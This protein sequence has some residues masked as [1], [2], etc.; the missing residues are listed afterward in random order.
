MT[1]LGERLAR[2]REFSGLSASELGLMAG[3]SHAIVGL[4]ERDDRPNPGA[5]TV[6]KLARVLGTTVE[7]LL[8]GVGGEPTKEKVLEAV[9]AA[10]ARLAESEL[11]LDSERPARSGTGG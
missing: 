10:R 1:G 6:L 9:E 4:L 5:L 7:Y 11:P 2:L 3:L 8:E